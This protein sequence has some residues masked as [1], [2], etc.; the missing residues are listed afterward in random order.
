[1]SG[2]FSK[3]MAINTLEQSAHRMEKIMSTTA[4]C[5]IVIIR[6]VLPVFYLYLL[7]SLGFYMKNENTLIQKFSEISIERE[8][9]ILTTLKELNVKIEKLSD[10]HN[11]LLA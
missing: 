7:F 1:M 5:T 9:D 8:S 10:D 11:Q 4:R 6:Y 2:L 3:K